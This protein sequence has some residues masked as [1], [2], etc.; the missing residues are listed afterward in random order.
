MIQSEVNHIDQT[1]VSLRRYDKWKE[2]KCID[3]EFET[4]KLKWCG[5][6]EF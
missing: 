4:F 2:G 5:V 3:S 6:N 1:T